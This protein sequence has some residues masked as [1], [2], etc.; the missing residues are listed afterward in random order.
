M[1]LVQKVYTKNIFKSNVL[2]SLIMNE[3]MYC[4][5]EGIKAL[6]MEF[7][8]V[9]LVMYNRLLFVTLIRKQQYFKI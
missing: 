2:E 4:N 5:S 3:H 1:E 6:M 8:N 9:Q 7:I